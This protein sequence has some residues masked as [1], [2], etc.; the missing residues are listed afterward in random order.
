MI[1]DLKGK[2][3][4]SKPTLEVMLAIISQPH[5]S[6][7]LHWLDLEIKANITKKALFSFSMRKFKAEAFLV[8]LWLFDYYVTCDG[9]D[10]YKYQRQPLA[11]V[12]LPQPHEYNISGEVKPLHLLY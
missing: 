4:E 8:G 7:T 9:H 12:S 11:F 6:Y 2:E 1:L 10:S 3:V 5:F